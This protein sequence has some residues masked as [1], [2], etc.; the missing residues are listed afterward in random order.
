MGPQVH[1][2]VLED[3]EAEVNGRL[4]GYVK[5][6]HY[7]ARPGDR[8]DDLRSK[9]SDWEAEGKVRVI[10]STLQQVANELGTPIGTGEVVTG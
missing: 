1:F 4:N 6:Q 3:F 9:I 2:Q 10:G 5:D 8:W 7:H